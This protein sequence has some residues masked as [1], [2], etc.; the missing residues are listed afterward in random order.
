MKRAKTKK[1]KQ[2]TKKS[3][4]WNN[5]DLREVFSIYNERYLGGKLALYNLSFS[6]IDELGHA[7]RY[8]TVGKRRDESDAW[9]IHISSRLRYSRRLWATTLLH[10]MVHLK[11]RNRHSCGLRGRRFNKRMRELAMAGAFDGLW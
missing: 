1:R 7:F 9:E 3:E 8:R 2:T 4:L 11:M 6:P 10:E 5:A